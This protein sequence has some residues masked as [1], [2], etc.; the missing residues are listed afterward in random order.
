MWT[1]I[2]VAIVALVVVLVFIALVSEPTTTARPRNR[3]Q[4]R[5]A[6]SEHLF[7][8]YYIPFISGSNYQRGLYVRA[9][10]NGGPIK[11]FRVDT[12]SVGVVVGASDIGS[13]NP[14]DPRPAEP[15]QII[16]TSSGVQLDGEWRDSIITFVDAIDDR[17]K[18]LQARVP[19]LAVDERRVLPGRVN[20]AREQ[21]SGAPPHV[22]MM[23]IGFGRH[24]STVATQEKEDQRN[25]LL[26]TALGPR[27]YI[28]DRRGIDLA[29]NDDDLSQFTTQ[30][31][32]RQPLGDDWQTPTGTIQIGGG[33]IRDTSVLVDTG[34]TNMMIGVP[35][36]PKMRPVDDGTR[37]RVGLLGGL[38]KYEFTVGDYSNPSAASKVTLIKPRSN[39]RTLNTGLHALATYDYLFDARRGLVGLRPVV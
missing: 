18:P 13:Q 22:F 20:P 7:D 5:L 6:D 26:A 8:S 25:P 35:D 33:Q 9:S 16:Y 28:L 31:L 2:V 34:L 3:Q 27:G 21:R 4:D 30:Q 23:G 29:L 17:G 36:L 37:I 39:N 38:L 11:S 24:S 32:V 19:V 10:I 14:I 15:G 1:E 12:G